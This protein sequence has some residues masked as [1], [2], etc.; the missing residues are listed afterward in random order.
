MAILSGCSG[1]QL[2]ITPPVPLEGK[3]D[4]SREYAPEGENGF[5][6]H[7]HLYL[8][9]ASQY[10]VRYVKNGTELPGRNMPKTETELLINNQL[11]DNVVVSVMAVAYDRRNRV[12]GTVSKAFLFNGDGK[13]MVEQ[14][15]LRDYM[16]H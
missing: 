7:S 15:V 2:I 16:F 5:Y 6:L 14:W 10:W 8:V 12:I 11:R 13:T 1:M 9:N 3:Q 4:Y